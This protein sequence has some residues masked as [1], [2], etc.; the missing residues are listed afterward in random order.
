MA[1][2]L[3]S[4]VDGGVRNYLEFSR[5]HEMSQWWH[6]LLLV[7]IGVAI[8][9][10]VVW[11]YRRDGREL[12]AGVA[13]S[14]LL[15]RVIAFAGV[16]LAFLGLERRGETQLSK[17]SRVVLLFDTSLSM[18][19]HDDP[20][21]ASSTTSRLQQVVDGLTRTAADNH[22]L[23][24][25]LRRKHHVIAYRFDQ[26]STPVELASLPKLTASNPLPAKS[27][28]AAN[29][30]AE[31]LLR[32]R[33]WLG[34]ALGLF[35]G[36]LI[37]SLVYVLSRSTEATAWWLFGSVCLFMTALGTG[38]I[39]HLQNSEVSWVHWWGDAKT[40]AETAPEEGGS[41]GDEG[42]PETESEIDWTSELRPTGTETRLGEALRYVVD[43]ER[44]GAI[45]GIVVFTD[46]NSNAGLTP[47]T[48]ATL[49]KSVPIPLFAVGLGSEKRPVNVRIADLQ[50]PPRVFPGDAFTVSG[51]LQSSGLAGR[52]VTVQLAVA[53]D[54][55]GADSALN[56]VVDE[57]SVR[58][59]DEEL[60]AVKF[61]VTPSLPGR[62]VYQ[63]RLNAPAEDH[64]AEDDRKQ[65]VVRVV[66]R[67][68]QVLL[69]AGG[70]TREYRF[71]RNLLFR[72][73]H[74]SAHVL[75][76]TRL[77]GMSQ[78]AD[79]V[80]T[81]F[82]ELPD[83]LF[84]YDA[85]VA[86]DIDWTALNR[87]QVD[88]LERWVAEKAGGLI[89]VAGNVH[90]PEW[91]SLSQDDARWSTIRALY[92]VVFYRES[93]AAF[94][95]S[96]SES[97][98]AW[99]LDFTRD[100]KLAEFLWLDETAKQSAQ[101][102]SAFEGVYGFFATKHAKSGA[103]V[104]ARFS[105][106]GISAA[107]EL[108][109]YLAGHFY[110]AG[111]VFFM[112]SGEMWRLRA[113]DE[114]YFEQFYTKLIRYVSQGRLLRDSSHG[115]LM[116][117][118]ERC[119][120]GDTVVVR[121]V[122][123]DSQHQPLSADSVPAIVISPDG[124][125]QELKLQAAAREMSHAGTFSG[126]FTAG[127]EG[128]YRIELA[129]P[130]TNDEE[131]LVREVRVRLPDLEVGQP[132]RNDAAL[133]QITQVTGGSYFVGMNTVTPPH[134]KSPLVGAILPQ[135]QVS[136]IPGAADKKFDQVLMIWLLTLICFALCLEWLL[137]RLHRL[138]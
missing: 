78:E 48:V 12:R 86:F 120:L 90:T 129:V 81:D 51:F 27:A 71:A 125:R 43:K 118:K 95:L 112:A 103:Q 14:L 33:I 41:E 67:M 99:P 17:D 54:T 63:L 9:G 128:D 53:E 100:G 138:T 42:Q 26:G 76:Q 21:S 132:E 3:F 18:G 97:D 31:T 92:P 49:A 46:G 91:T 70:P 47:E 13:A 94:H 58:L 11:L 62:Y 64:R 124:L 15:L 6:W 52:T 59:S 105:E 117:E 134:G 110:G 36:G 1:P 10:Y 8:L 72:D 38:A 61:E 113:V 55:P 2:I 57:R 109:V 80:L 131:L 75:L 115:L 44:G 96:K 50:I 111:R 32:L 23:L 101:A 77:P 60:V 83:D 66:E 104:Y 34:I 16:M 28:A 123:F 88:L 56:E 106:P 4:S 73:R 108:P 102:W 116:V 5:W 85:I 22:H 135:D 82:P 74:T 7:A 121:S 45:A 126:Q 40:A 137:R 136:F 87:H 98:Q 30:L 93:S 35:G 133:K 127:M 25:D 24:H 114:K 69:I 84:E 39:V 65:S 29:R 68:N 89:L 107:S 79:D 37:L 122:L 19:I 130:D 119:L 20:K